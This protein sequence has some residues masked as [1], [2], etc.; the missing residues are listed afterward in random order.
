[1]RGAMK[2]GA[3]DVGSNS[4]RCLAVSSRGG[5]LEYIAS[6]A[7]ITRLTEGIGSGSYEVRPE[8]V[9]RSATAIREAR[10]LLDRTGTGPENMVF[11]A[12]DSL[13][14]AVNRSRAAAEL[15]SAS[16]LHL[17]ILDSGKEAALSRAG[18]LLGIK[19]ADRVFDLGGGSLEI[20]G[21]DGSVSVPAGAVRMRARF[22]EDQ[23]AIRGEV[24]SLLSKGFPDPVRCLAGVG[25]TSSTAVMMLKEIPVSGYHPAMIHGH[26]VTA[27]DLEALCRGI[28]G[29]PMEDRRLVRGLEPG[30]ADI[31]VPG[32]VVIR[33]LLEVMHLNEYTHS[34]TDLLWAMC[35][36]T[37][38]TQ[39]FESSAAKMR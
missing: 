31:I 8:A 3:I 28:S 10:S 5:V 30:R 1:M 32:I 9:G 25:G 34:E 35:A 4:V 19:D 12:T 15:E 16:G 18:A 2:F 33:T 6:G 13:R 24:L 38:A 21:E 20:S 27:A 17:R 26:K 37:A 23:A 29:M 39:G 14:S 11:F 22:G 36:E 7:W